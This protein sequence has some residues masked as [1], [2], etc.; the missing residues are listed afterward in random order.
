M[1]SFLLK[2]ILIL[3]FVLLFWRSLVFE[4]LLGT[5]ETLFCSMSAHVKIIPLLDAHQLLMLSARTLTYSEPRTFS[6]I[7]FYNVPCIISRQFY[8]TSTCVRMRII[9][10]R[11]LMIIWF[12]WNHNSS[13]SSYYYYYYYYILYKF[14]CFFLRTRAN[15]VTGLWAFKFARKKQELNWIELLTQI[16]LTAYREDLQPSN[17][18]F[19]TRYPVSL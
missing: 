17:I 5:S 9:L 4:F 14:C 11:L 19:A 16:N 2:F 1:H 10:S 18:R 15:F 7:I 13:S 6:L 12:S 8:A 3:N